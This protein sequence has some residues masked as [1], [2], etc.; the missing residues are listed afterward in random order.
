MRLIADLVMTT[1]LSALYSPMVWPLRTRRAASSMRSSVAMRP[2]TTASS[3]GRISSSVVAVRKPSPPRLTPRIGTPRSPM[4][5]AVAAQH[6]E[7]VDE[8]GELI[9]AGGLDVRRR[10]EARRLLFQHGRQPVSPEP[11]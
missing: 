9:L 1:S 6:D 5:R 8:A 11:L 2:A 3:A 10:H 4:E 7:E